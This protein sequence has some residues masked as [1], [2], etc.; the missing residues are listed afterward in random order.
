MTSDVLAADR[1]HDEGSASGGDHD[2]EASSSENGQPFHAGE[3]FFSLLSLVESVVGTV[4][5]VV[6]NLVYSSTLGTFPAASFILTAAFY[7][8]AFIALSTI[9]IHR[10]S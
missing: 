7:S 2:G 4:L 3:V 9:V 1:I 8:S 5:P 10:S 6:Y